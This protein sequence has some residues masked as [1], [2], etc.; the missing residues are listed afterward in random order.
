MSSTSKLHECMS[1]LFFARQEGPG[2]ACP[3]GDKA[4]QH[5]V[6]KGHKWFILAEDCPDDECFLMSEYRNS[7]QN[8]SQVRTSVS[9]GSFINCA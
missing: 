1:D 2:G 7:E 5:A 4:L 6:E 9:V 3:Q 8:T